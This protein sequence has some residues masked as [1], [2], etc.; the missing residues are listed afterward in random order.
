[1]SDRCAECGCQDTFVE[2]LDERQSGKA[3]LFT[4]ITFCR[5]CGSKVVKLVPAP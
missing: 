2:Y 3:S 5:N 4:K 1:M